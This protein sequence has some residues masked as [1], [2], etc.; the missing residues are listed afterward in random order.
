MNWTEEEKT[1][2]KKKYGCTIIKENCPFKDSFDKTLP[3]D[4]Y[5]I[6]YVVNNKTFYDI[7][8]AKRKVDLFDMYYDK[9]RNHLISINFSQGVVNPKIWGYSPPEK[10]KKR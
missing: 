4:A 7:T 8:R 10:R 1:D 5:I 6:E 9:F 2:S 3:S